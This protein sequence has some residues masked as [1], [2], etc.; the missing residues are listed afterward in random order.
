M[1]LNGR[2]AVCDVLVVVHQ[3]AAGTITKVE[4]VRWV[5]DTEFPSQRKAQDNAGRMVVSLDDGTRASYFHEQITLP[6]K[7]GKV[8]LDG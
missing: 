2:G 5:W 4:T 1:M 6:Y 7:D 3:D 8:D